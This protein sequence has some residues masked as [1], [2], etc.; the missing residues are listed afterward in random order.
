MKRIALVL[1]AALALGSGAVV[2]AQSSN[3]GA[4]AA[5]A[6]AVGTAGAV[7]ETTLS[8]GGSGATTR[9]A[10]NAAG[11]STLAYFLRMVV[12]LALVLGLIYV[13]Y[14]ILKKAA[15]PKIA[16]SQAVRILASSSLGPGKTLHVVALG[17]KGYLVGATDSSI[18]LVAP[19]DD[20]EY[21]DALIL[22]AESKPPQKP[23]AGREF[24]A[25]LS[26]LMG[27]NPAGGRKKGSGEGSF[28]SGQRDRLR[29]F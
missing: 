7:D 27:G 2:A 28:L 16:E 13:V 5:A 25:V 22:E 14:R 19:I 18:N 10:T 21:L 4:Q 3:A 1:C 12:V 8:L 6:N 15:G 20:K 17:S 26:S 23:G 29:K 9:A 24:G 11:S